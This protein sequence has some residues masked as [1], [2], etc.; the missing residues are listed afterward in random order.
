LPGEFEAVGHSR[1]SRGELQ[2][3]TK[4]RPNNGMHPTP[5]HAAAHVRCAG[6]RVMP[7][8]G[9]HLKL[10]M[11]K[12]KN[13][14]V[15]KAEAVKRWRIWDNRQKKWWGEPCQSWVYPRLGQ[16]AADISFIRQRSV[17]FLAGRLQPS[18]GRLV[19]LGR[20]LKALPV[21]TLSQAAGHRQVNCRRAQRLSED[22]G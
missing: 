16:T 8:V 13:R 4:E 17:V 7:G 19:M 3:V 2:P 12:P 10:N 6:A 5:H 21:V 22:K 14:F 1:I 18:P 11:G 9:P 15:A 20:Q